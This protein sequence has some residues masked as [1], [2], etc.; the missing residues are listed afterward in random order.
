MGERRGCE[1]GA[2]GALCATVA[3]TSYSRSPHGA[4]DRPEPSATGEGSG[5]STFDAWPGKAGATVGSG[6]STG[7]TT[8]VDA[9]ASRCC[10]AV[11]WSSPRDVP[12][13]DGAGSTE[14]VAGIEA[15]IEGAAGRLRLAVGGRE[16]VGALDLTADMRARSATFALVTAAAS[17]A[18][19]EDVELVSLASAAD[20]GSGA[21]EVITGL[22]ACIEGADFRFA[23]GGRET[24]VG[25]VGSTSDTRAFDTDGVASGA[26]SRGA[27]GTA[28]AMCADEES[29][30][31]SRKGVPGASRRSVVRGA[32][33]P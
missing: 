7:D 20:G 2:P 18:P 5:E 25:T 9:G 24:V 21:W 10:C 16:T 27:A 31:A 32:A 30:R 19:A 22:E 17:F 8:R 11:V 4:H 23:E 1:P 6:A 15:G 26:M 12:A 14:T 3:A 33:S 28:G 13:D 29:S